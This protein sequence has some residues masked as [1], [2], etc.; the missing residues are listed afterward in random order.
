MKK[1][2]IV[3]DDEVDR[4]MIRRAIKLPDTEFT[5]VGNGAD[6]IKS[7]SENEYDCIVL[8]H[9][10]PDYD[11]ISL[12]EAIRENRSLTPVVVAT[13]HGDEMLVAKIFKA[14]GTDYIPKN[15][16]NPELLTEI[17]K[18]SIFRYN[19]QIKSLAKDLSLLKRVQSMVVDKLEGTNAR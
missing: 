13:G 4:E 2:L 15:K 11:S 7:L 8:D 1:I 16:I 10:L 19:K 5:D 9:L 6:C 12:I 18:E 14:G 17:V 3:D